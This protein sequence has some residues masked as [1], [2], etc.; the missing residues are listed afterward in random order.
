MEVQVR[1]N[2]FLGGSLLPLHRVNMSFERD[3]KIINNI[4]QYKNVFISIK[5]EVCYAASVT[6]HRLDKI[7]PCFK[8]SDKVN[9]LLSIFLIKILTFLC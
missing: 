7:D 5:F 8:V 1:Q 2:N 6:V 4:Q 3:I 9:A